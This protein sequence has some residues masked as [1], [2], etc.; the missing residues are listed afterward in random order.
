MNLKIT[1]NNEPEGLVTEETINKLFNNPQKIV[2]VKDGFCSI[3]QDPLAKELKVLEVKY[4]KG[5]IQEQKTRWHLKFSPAESAT[6]T[7]KVMFPEGFDF[8]RGGKLPGLYGGTAPRGGKSIAVDDGF[9]IRTMWREL[10]VL[11]AY[12]YFMDMDSEKK[13][14]E[15]FLWTNAADKNVSITKYMWKSMDTHFKERMYITPNKWHTLKTYVKMNTPGQQD[16]KIICWL[17][18]EEAVNVDLRFRK[19]MSFGIDTFAFTTFFGGSDPSWAPTK[20]EV[21]YFGDISIDTGI[22]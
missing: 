13:N 21:V 9:T 11:C 3:V 5:I 2:G 22:V 16:G 20:D 15:N 8:V 4:P 7:Y 17:D 12:V 10:G 6:L 14:G 1:F 19:D 18:G